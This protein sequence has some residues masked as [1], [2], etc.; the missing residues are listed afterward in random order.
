M[1]PARPFPLQPATR[2]LAPLAALFGIAGVVFAVS[3]T[4]R[5]LFIAGTAATLLL[6]LLARLRRPLL[7]LEEDGYRVEVAGKVT[8]RVK[9]AEVKQARAVPAQQAMYLDTGQPGRNLLLPARSGFGFRFAR[10]DELYR[11]LAERLADRLVVVE[12]LVPSATWS[13]GDLGKPT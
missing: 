7:F 1:P 3:S 4:A 10:Q 8:L 13:G 9:F 2:W 11:L 5:A 12:T 6:A